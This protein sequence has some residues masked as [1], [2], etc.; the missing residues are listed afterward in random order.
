MEAERLLLV[1]AWVENETAGSK[2]VARTRVARIENRHIVLLCHLVD[3]REEGKE[4]LL[5]VDVLFTVSREEDVL[6]LF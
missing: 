4:V 1:D 6:A 5:G 2:A 3:G